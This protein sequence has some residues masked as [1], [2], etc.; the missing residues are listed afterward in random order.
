MVEYCSDIAE[1]M[2]YLE[3]VGV[4]HRDLAA[5]NV[6][7]DAHFTAKV[8]TMSFMMMHYLLGRTSSFGL[9]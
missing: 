7:L 8:R 9:N 1:G 4:V 2:V 3:S 6:L 5:R